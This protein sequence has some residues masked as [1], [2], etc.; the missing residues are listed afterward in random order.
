MQYFTTYLT[1]TIKLP[2]YVSYTEMLKIVNSIK[3]VYHNQNVTVEKKTSFREMSAFIDISH[4]TERQCRYT[5]LAL[6]LAMT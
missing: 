4:L 5:N 3:I 1:S 2:Y 6:P